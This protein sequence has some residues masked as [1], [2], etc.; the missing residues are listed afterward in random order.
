M[1]HKYLVLSRIDK[2]HL[3]DEIDRQSGIDL[4]LNPIHAVFANDTNISLM[5]APWEQE[6]LDPQ[7]ATTRRHKLAVRVSVLN[8]L[9]S[10]P[11]TD[12]LNLDGHAG[13]R[14]ND[15]PQSPHE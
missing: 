1:P 7:N 8:C 15:I 6:I 12:Q 10:V 3:L 5:L 4:F 9:V 13:S 2:R 11:R 14:S